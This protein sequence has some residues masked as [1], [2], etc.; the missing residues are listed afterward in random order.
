MQATPTHGVRT[1]LDALCRLLDPDLYRVRA[2]TR[3]ASRSGAVEVEVDPTGWVLEV[4]FARFDEAL[5]DPGRL[6]GA[7]REALLMAELVRAGENAVLR[8]DG[9]IEA[10]LGR[11]LIAGERRIAPR[12]R[13]RLPRLEMPRERRD[14]PRRI[15]ERPR[16]RRFEG[17]SRDGEI[18]VTVGVTS[19]V[20]GFRADP[21]WLRRAPEAEIRYAIKEAFADVYEQGET[22]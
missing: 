1:R 15:A 9:A 19:G 3:G 6:W 17:V 18:R 11:Q 12:P 8:G 21:D 4:R 5:R 20:T 13:P 10:E 16:E 14:D 7:L 22:A 2:P